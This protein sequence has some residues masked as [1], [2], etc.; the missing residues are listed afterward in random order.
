LLTRLIGGPG[1]EQQ[2]SIRA[3]DDESSGTPRL[4]P[5]RSEKKDNAGNL[6]FE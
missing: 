3:F 6:K 2:V 4:G 1:K 5:Q